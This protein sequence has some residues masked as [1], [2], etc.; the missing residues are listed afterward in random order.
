MILSCPRII[1][2]RMVVLVLHVQVRCCLAVFAGGCHLYSL[3]KLATS[4]VLPLSVF[5]R[6]P[7]SFIPYRSG[8]HGI[9]SG[10]RWG[11]QSGFVSLKLGRGR[12][13]ETIG[14]LP[15]RSYSDPDP[16]FHSEL[17][18]NFRILMHVLGRKKKSNLFLNFSSVRVQFYC[19]CVG[20]A[21]SSFTTQ[22]SSDLSQYPKKARIRVG[23]RQKFESGSC[24]MIAWDNTYWYD[25]CPIAG[26]CTD[27]ISPLKR[28][29]K[30]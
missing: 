20:W 10:L 12:V 4:W 1:L 15:K 7:A 3:L 26:S 28:S 27:S 13:H 6:P 9:F 22:Q 5:A 18:P 21:T 14:A 23:I 29:S 16:T 2:V 17:E 8:I 11:I 30:L 19:I 25:V 24:K